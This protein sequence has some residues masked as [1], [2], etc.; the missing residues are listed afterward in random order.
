MLPDET[1][2]LLNVVSADDVSVDRDTV[3]LVSKGDEEGDA[4]EVGDGVS[5]VG[6]TVVGET[7][8]SLSVVDPLVKHSVSV[9]SVSEVV[10]WSVV[11]VVGVC[12]GVADVTELEVVSCT[13]VSDN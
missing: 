3:V 10:R 2:V 4:V 9:V 6:L 7:V 1:V 11:A 5:V 8:L 12:S 13:V